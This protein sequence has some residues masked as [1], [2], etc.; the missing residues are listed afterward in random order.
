M[1]ILPFQKSV[2]FLG[3]IDPL[4][5]FEMVRTCVFSF[6]VTRIKNSTETEEVAKSCKMIGENF[7]LLMSLSSTCFA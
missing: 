5:Q 2:C 7:Q 4:E 3:S 6:G 1:S